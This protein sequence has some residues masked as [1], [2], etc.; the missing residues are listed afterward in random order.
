MLRQPRRAV[1]NLLRS[2]PSRRRGGAT[3]EF[4]AAVPRMRISIANP[5][6]LNASDY[7][8]TPDGRVL[9][10]TATPDT[11]TPPAT[12]ILNWTQALKK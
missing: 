2:H 12:I 5:Q 1:P 3:F 4:D 9:V 8:V 7:D 10:G 6:S 11:R